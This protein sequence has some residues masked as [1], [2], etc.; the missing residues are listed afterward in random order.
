MQKK[1][2]LLNEMIRQYI[3]YQEPI[4]SETLKVSLGVNISSATIRNYFKILGQEGV[5]VQT[6]ISSGRVP[7]ICA[8][9]DYWRKKLS[10]KDLH[11]TLDSSKLESS[12][13]IFALSC[14]IKPNVA[15]NFSQR[16]LQVIELDEAQTLV[17]C[18]SKDR[19]AI[20]LVANMSRFC[21]ELQGMELED[22]IKIAKEVCA[23][24]LY[25]ALCS[26]QSAPK[27]FGLEYLGE[28]VSSQ[29]QIALEILNGEM[30]SR[31]EN[32]VFFPEKSEYM[33]LAHN[34][35]YLK[36]GEDS[37]AKMLCIGKLTKDYEGFYE[38]L[39]KSA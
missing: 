26:L 38:A 17:L 10:P 37:E 36:N 11:P 22:I 30:F 23:T 2:F 27:F 20:P 7:T 18:F 9:K 15:Q 16:L 39:E 35:T 28:L 24:S 12:C 13:K 25:N 34:A 3:K 14:V 1:E 29:P 5:I 19:V 8:L 21:K 33:V 32:A 6:H 4:G 31:L